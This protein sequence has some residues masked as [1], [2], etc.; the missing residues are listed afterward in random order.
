M[1]GKTG[2]RACVLAVLA[3]LSPC[4]S[5]QAPSLAG[6]VLDAAQLPVPGAAVALRDTLSGAIRQTSTD[7]SGAFAFTAIVRGAYWL[8]ASHNGFSGQ[9]RAVEI[10][11]GESPQLIDL[12]LSIEGVRETITVVS[13]SRVNEGLDDSPV[14]VE[15][16]TR[17]QMLDSGSTRVSDVLAEMPGVVT[18]RGATASA[19]GEQ[20]QGIDSRQVLVLLDGLP[21][22]GARGVKSGVMN[23]NRQSVGRLEQVEVVKG[24]ASAV[25]GSDAIGGV[26]NL[27]PREP[28]APLETELDL[29]AGSLSALDARGSVGMQRGRFSGFLDLE[30]HQQQAYGLVPASPITVGPHYGR[31]DLFLRTRYAVSPRAAFSVMANGYHNAESA[32]TNGDS[33]LS[34]TNTNDRSQNYAVIADLEPISASLL[35]L[36]AYAGRYDENSWTQAVANPALTGVSNLNERYHRAD[37]TV[38]RSIGSRQ[39][40]QGGAEWAQSLYRG[41]NRLVGD[42]AGQ[43]VTTADVWFQD[44]IQVLRRA[45]LTLGGRNQHHSTFGNAI[46]PKAG[47]VVRLSGALSLRAG[48]GQGFRAPDLGQLYYRFANPTGFYQVIGNPN[49]RPETSHSWSA[50]AAYAAGRF[51]L[52]TNLYRNDVRD[53]IDSQLIGRPATGDD[54]SAIERQ[55]GIPV[56]FAP[57]LGRGLYLNRNLSRIRTRGVEVQGEARLFRDFNVRAA[58]TYLDAR[59][60]LTG[61]ELTL[62]HRH[63]GFAAA[64]Y[65]N[66]RLSAVANLR[67]SFFS[68]YLLNATGARAYPYRIWDLYGSKQVG[69]GASLYA[70]VDNLFDS[71]DPKLRLAVPT[72]DRPDYGRTFR[73][74]VRY[75]FAREGR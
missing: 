75:S 31:N 25:Y 18:R 62:R 73:V 12:H 8:S 54:L 10:T 9:G 3:T 2:G 24:A 46:V 44:R 71:T 23:L 61:A 37:A 36:R 4:L 29:S 15:A 55:Y 51:H 1:T 74:G 38:S 49:L 22:T 47:L 35:Q 21:L 67:G 13:S 50:G 5:A 72:F 58:Y 64:E 32:R 43:Q 39:Y 68:S 6:R 26:I 16:V 27:I 70:S 56:E 59:D 66:R 17:R 60:R 40:L 41:A 45:T 48:Y 28:S 63:Q 52:T 7:T 42:N 65:A 20:V 14:K 34:N 19:G 53:L 30:R 33:G 69:R 57:L 11:A